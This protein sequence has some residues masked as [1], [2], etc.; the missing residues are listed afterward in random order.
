MRFGD[1]KFG[2]VVT[3]HVERQASLVKVDSLDFQIVD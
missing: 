3:Q 1:L 2:V